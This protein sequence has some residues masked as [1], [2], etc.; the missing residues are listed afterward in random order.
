MLNVLDIVYSRHELGLVSVGIS[1]DTPY[2]SP[3]KHGRM[4]QGIQ[5][6]T[7]HNTLQDVHVFAI[8]CGGA[9]TRGQFQRKWAKRNACTLRPSF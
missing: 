8:P 1:H 5:L 2:D 9:R 6:T 4:L 7:V 3:A